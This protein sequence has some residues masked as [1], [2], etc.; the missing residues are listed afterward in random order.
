M[1][2]G[3]G[4]TAWRRALTRLTCDRAP[5]RGPGRAPGG[6]A[7][8]PGRTAGGPAELSGALTA[9]L[10]DVLAAVALA[11]AGPDPPPPSL[12]SR[13]EAHRCSPAPPA[14]PR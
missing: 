7:R 8:G 1:L 10:I 11:G 2:V 9:E 13:G 4:V 3:R 5:A 6:P 14:R 12:P